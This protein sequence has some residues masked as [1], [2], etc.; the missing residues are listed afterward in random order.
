MRNKIKK[1]SKS[2]WKNLI[3]TFAPTIFLVLVLLLIYNEVLLETALYLISTLIL[4]L[5]LSIQLNTLNK[6]KYIYS[7]TTAIL[8]LI[9]FDI[10]FWFTKCSNDLDCKWGFP[11]LIIIFLFYT[12]LIY[13]LTHV[14][15]KIALKID[16]R[17]K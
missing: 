10:I 15:N 7:F 8:L 16:G 5:I 6:H 2:S 4:G 9:V 12:S 13:V 17:K 3:I 14:F 11:A 1:S